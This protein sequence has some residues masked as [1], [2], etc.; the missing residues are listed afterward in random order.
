[1]PHQLLISSSDT[2]D[3]VLRLT[4]NRREHSEMLL[5]CN[6]RASLTACFCS[7]VSADGLPPI[8]PFIFAAVTP[9]RTRSLNRSPPNSAI[10]LKTWNISF[11]LGEL[12]SIRSFKD[13]IFAPLQ[14][15]VSTISSMSRSDR[16]NR[17]KVTTTTRSSL[18]SCESILL[19]SARFHFPPE[20]T[21]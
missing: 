19:S 5:F 6:R 7:T 21:S 13:W 20:E 15:I 2:R 1:M 18:R 14:P 16:D 12:V 4:P 3:I 17:S 11:P 8:R 10:T 9:S